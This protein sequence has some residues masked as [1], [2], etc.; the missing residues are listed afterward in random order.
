M[1]PA[2]RTEKYQRMRE[3]LNEKQWRHYL[4]LEAQECGSVMHVA[5]EAGVSHNTIRRALRELEAG[6]RYS[7]GQRQRKS[8][9]GR[10]QATEKDGSLRADLESLLEPKG[11]PMSLLKWTTKSVAHLKAALEQMGHEV[12]ETTIR[13]LLH[14]L[15][16]SARRQ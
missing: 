8:G 1:M 13:R 16:Y 15:G 2:S 10:K 5:Q 7:P 3:L 12:A 11:D 9:G 14:A 4:A 6:E